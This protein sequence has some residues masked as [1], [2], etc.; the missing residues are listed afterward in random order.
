MQVSSGEGPLR[1][2]VNLVLAGDG[3]M[4]VD[5]ES[6]NR[7]TK[8]LLQEVAPWSISIQFFS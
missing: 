4:R 8:R 3:Q 5:Y 2:S 1:L 7:A 6:L